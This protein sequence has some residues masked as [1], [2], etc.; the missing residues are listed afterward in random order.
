MSHLEPVEL[1][2]VLARRL[3]AARAENRGTLLV[4]WPAEDDGDD[5]GGDDDGGDDDGDDDGNNDEHQAATSRPILFWAI[6][7]TSTCSQ[8]AQS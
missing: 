3:G 1:E 4:A 5:D 6:V 2:F 8:N 7:D